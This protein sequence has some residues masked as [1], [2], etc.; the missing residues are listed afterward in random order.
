M[1]NLLK[2]KLSLIAISLA[3]VFIV[4][5]CTKPEPPRLGETLFVVV[6]DADGHVG[7]I[8]VNDGS[9]EIV[10]DKAYAAAHV[11]PEGGVKKADFHESDVSDIFAA[12]LAAKPIPPNSFMLYFEFGTDTFTNESLYEF[13]KVFAD[14]WSRQHFAVDV[15]GHTDTKG[16]KKY[17]AGLSLER[18]ETVRAKLLERGI[19]AQAVSAIGRGELDL[20]IDTPDATPEPRNRRVE[21]TIR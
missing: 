13:E 20:L 3:L 18:A 17:N 10:L 16:K 5:A 21:I 14:I 12:A 9:S 7:Q 19:E 2:S 6:P 8:T 11:T 15:I 4:A 1:S